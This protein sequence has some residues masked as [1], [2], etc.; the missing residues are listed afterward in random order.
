MLYVA[1]RDHTF[2]GASY[3][4]WVTPLIL[5]TTQHQNAGMCWVKYDLQQLDSRKAFITQLCIIILLSTVS[6]EYLKQWGEAIAKKN[7]NKL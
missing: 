4:N 5:K 6:Q 2:R 3:S 1:F 7:T